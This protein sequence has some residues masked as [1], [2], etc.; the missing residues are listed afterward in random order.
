M[1]RLAQQE[2]W[3]A[4]W[5][6][7]AVAVDRSTLLRPS[8]ALMGGIAA[9]ALVEAGLL[10]AGPGVSRAVVALVLLI[11]V[12]VSGLLG[13]RLVA[14]AVALVAAIGFA[15][16]LPAIGSPA[17]KVG[18][19]VAAV[20]LF[21]LVAIIAGVLLSSVLLSDRRRITAELLTLETLRQVDR[22]RAALLRSVS[23]DL[24]TPLAT[25][26]A[27]A[28]DLRGFA[29]QPATRDELLDLVID[30]SERL[31]RIVG[32]LLSLSRIEAGALLPER[33]PVDLGE[34]VESCVDRLRRVTSRVELDVRVEPGLPLVSVDYS[35]IDQVVA[36]LLENA[37]RHS[38]PG[39]TV[40]LRLRRSLVGVAIEVTDQGPGFDPSV[41]YRLFEPFAS[42]T[43]SGSSGIGLAICKSVVEAHG[44]TITAS[45]PGWGGAKIV[46]EVPVDG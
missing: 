20:T 44:G 7:P 25:I 18:D 28:T 24:R 36:N 9:V 45:E 17:V 13:G 2:G 10:I 35:Q 27:A 39:G 32:N 6:D 31:D 38:P 41:R 19:N 15:V 34:L 40:T 26:R 5:E 11:P 23:H 8:W 37:V 14:L 3:S 33:Q 22:D 43:G 21:V 4:T 1:V 30:E 46:V 12:A 29:H 42:A 16:L